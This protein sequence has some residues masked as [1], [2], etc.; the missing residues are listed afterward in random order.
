MLIVVLYDR[1]AIEYE[2]YELPEDK[3]RPRTPFLMIRWPIKTAAASM[4]R[5]DEVCF[6]LFISP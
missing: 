2:P 3:S 6:S 4:N 5:V 1:T